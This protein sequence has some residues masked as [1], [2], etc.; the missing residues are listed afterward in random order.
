MANSRVT[1]T[2]LQIPPLNYSISFGE[3]LTSQFIYKERFRTI[4]VQTG[5]A[6]IPMSTIF[7]N[8]NGPETNWN[9]TCANNYIAAFN[10]DYNSTNLFN[11]TYI[12][13]TE[14]NGLGAVVIEANYPNAIF[15]HTNDG[16]GIVDVIIQNETGFNAIEITNENFSTATNLCEEVNLNITTSILA[17][18][19]YSNF[20]NFLANT[21]NP[22]TLVALRNSEVQITLIDEN[23]F[24]APYVFKT[25]QSL[26]S[27]NFVKTINNS[28]NGATL[29]IQNNTQFINGVPAL[30]VEYSLDND[31]WQTSNVFSGLEA[32]DYTLYVRDQFG[33]SFTQDFNVNETSVYVPH[34]Y[35][36][37]SNSIRFAQRIT[38]GDASNYKNDENTLSCEVDVQLPYKDV[39]LFQTSDVI[40]TQFESNY[41]FKTVKV[42]RENGNEVTIPIVQKTNNIGIK[43]KRDAI[44]Y[45]LEPGKTGIYFTAGNIYN[46]DTNLVNGS[47]SLNGTLPEWAKVGSYVNI[48]SS[49]HIIENSFFDEDKNSDVIVISENYTGVDLNIIIGCIYNL[50]EYE[51]YEF[52]ID[53]LDFIDET[54]RV[55]LINQDDNFGILT[56]LSEEI[57]VKVRHEDT[58]CHDYWNDDNTDVYYATGIRHRLRISFTKIEG[59]IDEESSIHKT[60]TSTIMLSGMMYKGK[61]IIYE[62]LTEGIWEKLC[63]ALSHKNL[64][65]DNTKFVKSGELE[66]DAALDDT[67]LYVLTAKLLK[68]STVYSTDGANVLNGSSSDVEIPGI[69]EGDAGF[70]KY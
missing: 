28:P 35:I 21:N 4:R 8:G 17:V 27:F 32:G 34:F 48:G 9:G 15:T 47:H 40:T 1:I 37:Q 30:I 69:I 58:L 56:H 63:R 53:M 67:N 52:S 26:I 5:Q 29:S 49:W 18:D 11:I 61:Q 54:I 6:T 22:F 43:D 24:I 36:S 33:C 25:P 70:M 31:E 51:I 57:Y 46:Y 44:K 59:F 12:P 64:F 13:P 45:N 62:P 16:N 66:T 7:D 3:L 23:G 20:G 10:L 41:N 39:Q 68:A 42:I 2:F 14:N 38:F 60:D 50:F 65:I 19:I 55:Q